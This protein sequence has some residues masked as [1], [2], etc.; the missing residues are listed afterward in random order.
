VVGR[1]DAMLVIL[2]FAIAAAGSYIALQLAPSASGE[3]P[4][5]RFQ[6]VA[7][8]AGAM[9]L[10]IWAMHFT[11]MAAYSIPGMTIGYRWDIT[12]LS[13]VVAIAYTG[14]SRSSNEKYARR[15]LTPLNRTIHSTSRPF[16]AL[17]FVSARRAGHAPGPDPRSFRQ[18][19]RMFAA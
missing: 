7:P 14:S 13:L 8:A 9:G 10:T 6:G 19:D 5:R 11:G 16:R 1:Y 2:S 18:W 12:L 17:L 3:G 15:P 4:T